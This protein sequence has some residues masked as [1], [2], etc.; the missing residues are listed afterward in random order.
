MAITFRSVCGSG[1]DSSVLA[2]RSLIHNLEVIIF[3]YVWLTGN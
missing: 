2:R 1:F 3:D